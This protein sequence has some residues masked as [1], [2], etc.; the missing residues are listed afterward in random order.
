MAR[1]N[2]KRRASHPKR[3]QRN[4]G[5]TRDKNA[6]TEENLENKEPKH[7]QK[8]HRYFGCP[9]CQRYYWRTVY[10]KKPVSRCVYDCH[11]K[12]D[13][14]EKTYEVGKGYFT[15]S[16]CSHEWTNTPARHHI[17][18]PCQK[19]GKSEELPHRIKKPPPRKG[20]RQSNRRHRCEECARTGGQCNLHPDRMWSSI[21][22]ETGSTI[23]DVTSLMSELSV[24][25]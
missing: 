3:T 8:V 6:L 4:P 7:G 9:V 2:Q 22:D 11:N 13:A 12:L 18:Q 1:K 5:T 14:V 15:C 19:C 10:E 23:S 25:S 20:P 21:H 16:Q 17:H 24:G